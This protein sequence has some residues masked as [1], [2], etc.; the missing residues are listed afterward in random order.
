MRAYSNRLASLLVRSA[1][2]SEQTRQLATNILSRQQLHVIMPS[3]NL[4]KLLDQSSM[5]AKRN[6]TH[7]NPQ[8]KTLIDLVTKELRE[9]DE[10][11]EQEI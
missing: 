5:V 11:K 1:F 8:I 7:A 3:E 10:R 6:I 2:A 9:D 4:T